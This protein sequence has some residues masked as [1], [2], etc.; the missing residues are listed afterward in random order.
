MIGV[1]LSRWT[2]TYF[3]AAL[4]AFLAAQ[5][6]MLAGYGYPNVLIEAPETLVLVHLIALGWFSLLL[7]G[8]LFPFVPVFFAPPPSPSPPPVTG[9]GHPAPT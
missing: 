2:I 9:A 3:A 5:I 6:L 8:A 7:S 1:S 4:V